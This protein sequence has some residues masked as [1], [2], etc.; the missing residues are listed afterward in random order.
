ML[1]SGMCAKRPHGIVSA[2][3]VQSRRRPKVTA[4]TRWPRGAGHAG[5]AT[6]SPVPGQV[7]CRSCRPLCRGVADAYESNR[8]RGALK[9]GAQEQAS[10]LLAQGPPFNPAERGLA[11]HAVHLSASSRATRSSGSSTRSSTSRLEPSRRRSGPGASSSRIRH[12]SR[13]GST[14]GKRRGLAKAQSPAAPVSNDLR[15]GVGY[16]GPSPESQPG[17]CGRTLNRGATTPSTRR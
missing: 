4:Y 1:L 6:S 13:G 17:R 11:R 7:R 10:G 14:P 3:M 15:H 16:G 8:T 2:H 5:P 12:A 9:P